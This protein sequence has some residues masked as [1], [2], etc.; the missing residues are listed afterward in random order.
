MMKEAHYWFL[1][2]RSFGHSLM[3]FA[4]HLSIVVNLCDMLA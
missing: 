4:G 3:V 2:E 1:C